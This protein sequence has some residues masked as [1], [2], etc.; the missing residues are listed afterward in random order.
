M[1]EKICRIRG[2]ILQSMGTNSNLWPRI[3]L[4]LWPQIRFCPHRFQCH[5]FESVP[6]DSNLSPHIAV[7]GHRFESV[8]TESQY[9]ATDSNMW[10]QIAICSHR[11]GYVGTDCN[12]WEQIRI[13]GHTFKLNYGHRFEIYQRS[14]SFCIIF[15]AYIFRKT[16]QVEPYPAGPVSSK[17]LP[18]IL[19]I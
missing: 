8:P 13:C 4:N 11:F 3:R 18:W 1:K 17:M 6:T 10:E 7:C 16:E 14:F 5:R 9:V 15:L 19:S 2:H 12:L